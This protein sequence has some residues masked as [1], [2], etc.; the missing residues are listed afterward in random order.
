MNVQEETYR[1][2]LEESAE[3]IKML[4]V[5]AAGCNEHPGYRG[6]KKP[7]KKCKACD[8]IHFTAEAVRTIMIERSEKLQKMDSSSLITPT[9]HLVDAKGNPVAASE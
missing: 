5:L 9:T 4:L 6:R 3:M 8:F 7:A 1:R 2:A